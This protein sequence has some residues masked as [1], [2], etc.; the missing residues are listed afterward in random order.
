MRNLLTTGIA[1]HRTAVRW[2]IIASAIA[3]VLFLP[4]WRGAHAPPA[5]P[6]A[7]RSAGWDV[8]SVSLAAI[9]SWEHPTEDTVLTVEPEG[10]T[11]HQ[12]GRDGAQ[13]WYGFFGGADLP[14][15][16]VPKPDP[17]RLYLVYGPSQNRQALIVDGQPGSTLVLLSLDERKRTV[18][19]RVGQ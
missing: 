17:E 9:G 18:Y 6:T 19:R 1:N 11:W 8:P 2:L 15:D 10:L 3:T 13:V 4:S 14:P 16:L 12:N 5:A 7:T